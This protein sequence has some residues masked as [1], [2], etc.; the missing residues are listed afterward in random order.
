M[1]AMIYVYD[2]NTKELLA[3]PETEEPPLDTCEEGHAVSCHHW[4]ELGET[5]PA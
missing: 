1:M 3:V 5:I 2:L 4:Q